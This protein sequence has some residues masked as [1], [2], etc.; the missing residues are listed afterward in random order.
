LL[1]LR[2]V[3]VAKT[4]PLLFLQLGYQA[5]AAGDEFRAALRARLLVFRSLSG[6]SV[7]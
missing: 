6:T 5:P 1:L 4:V 7:E 3:L 2:E